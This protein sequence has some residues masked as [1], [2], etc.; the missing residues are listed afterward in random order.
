MKALIVDDSKTMRM[1]L[2]RE[3]KERNCEI[4]EASNGKEGL[5]VL[6]QE[7]GWD[8]ILLDWN[9][10][11]MNGIEFI[12]KVRANPALKSVPIVMVTTE[13]SEE[14][15][16]ASLEAGAACFISKPFR[17]EDLTAALDKVKP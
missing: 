6:G 12:H 5:A 11:E 13:S 16:K 4:R 1:I 2:S 7:G 10:P 17:W 8:F 3:L 14:Y 15:K 9:M